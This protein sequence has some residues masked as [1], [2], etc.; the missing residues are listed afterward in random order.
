MRFK[1]LIGF[2]EDS[3][4]ISL[5]I[6]NGENHNSIGDQVWI[7]DDGKEMVVYESADKE[8]LKEAM[9]LFEVNSRRAFKGAML[10]MG[11]EF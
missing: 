7:S 10:R 6:E 11:V 9:D 8:V 3:S 4:F 5:E 2:L 1:A